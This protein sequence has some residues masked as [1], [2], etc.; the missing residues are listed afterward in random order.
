MKCA[1]SNCLHESKDIL[2]GEDFKKENK[3]YYHTDCWNYKNKIN[4]VI[5]LFTEQV[6]SNI[7]FTVLRSIVNNL[8]FIQKYEPEY[9]LYAI[10][11]AVDHPQ[12]KLTYPPGL[13]RICKDVDVSESY[14]KLKANMILEGQTVKIDEVQYSNFELN[15]TKKKKSVSDLFGGN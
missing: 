14:K 11:Y 13:Y 8:V 3:K 9:I 10:K 4:E 7:V 15:N 12:M 6:N 2:D 1:Y 5:T